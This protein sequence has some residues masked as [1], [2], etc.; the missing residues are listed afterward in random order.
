MHP[1]GPLFES[2]A[3]LIKRILFVFAADRNDFV[4]AMCS[5]SRKSLQTGQ[6]FRSPLHKASSLAYVSNSKCVSHFF[7]FIHWQFVCLTFVVIKHITGTFHIYQKKRYLFIEISCS[8]L[9]FSLSH[10]NE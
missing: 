6:M 10:P 5:F 8:I 7:H 1:D 9:H 4:R 3:K 2:R